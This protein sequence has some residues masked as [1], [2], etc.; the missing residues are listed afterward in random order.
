M[1]HCGRPSAPIL[2]LVFSDFWFA[3]TLQLPVND[4]P[5][6]GRVACRSAVRGLVTCGLAAALCFCGSLRASSVNGSVDENREPLSRFDRGWSVDVPAGG[7]WL[8]DYASNLSG[9]FLR[10]SDRIFFF[11]GLGEDTWQSLE[12]S[13]HYGGVL[14]VGA[15]AAMYVILL[16]ANTLGRVKPSEPLQY[17]G[18]SVSLVG[19]L[20]T[21]MWQLK[22]LY[23]HGL[24]S[25]LWNVGAHFIGGLSS[26]QR[27]V[28][29]RAGSDHSN[30]SA[31]HALV[32]ASVLSAWA[33]E[34]TSGAAS[35]KMMSS[36]DIQLP[37]CLAEQVFVSIV[38]ED[39]VSGGATLRMHRIPRALRSEKR[40][41]YPA[42]CQAWRKLLKVMDRD[43]IDRLIIKPRSNPDGTSDLEIDFSDHRSSTPAK[44]RINVTSQQ[45]KAPWIE[46]FLTEGFSR[47][48]VDELHS[49]LQPAYIAMMWQALDC[50]SSLTDNDVVAV[51]R[52][53]TLHQTD[54]GTRRLSWITNAP[55]EATSWVQ[56]KQ[57]KTILYFNLP[58]F[59]TPYL[60]WVDG[61]IGPSL[62]LHD[63]SS[64]ELSLI[65]QYRFSE[66]TSY[67][68]SGELDYM[69]RYIP[70]MLLGQVAIPGMKSFISFGSNLSGKIPPKTSSGMDDIEDMSVKYAPGWLNNMETIYKVFLWCNFRK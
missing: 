38:A 13:F 10:K 66:R 19:M 46:H 62:E 65:S 53:G 49:V 17:L 43:R 58:Q 36:V 41:H 26:Y 21:W 27:G 54:T 20:S 60:S 32:L 12:T 42:G 48:D 59:E 61:Y 70:H 5:W 8:P 14:P 40:D 15:L 29:R 57:G 30:I 45:G 22:S 47:S 63:G 7:G 69:V 39:S 11:E 33:V 9:T 52:D 68:L 1:K 16:T 50:Y 64:S 4:Y 55:P 24:S 44:L 18:F 51:C 56:D 25:G 35:G 34:N 2:P 28:N 3:M 23:Y 6:Q 31:N 37:A 67:A